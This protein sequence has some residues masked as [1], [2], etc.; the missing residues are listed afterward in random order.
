MVVM[1]QMIHVFSPYLDVCP[2]QLYSLSGAAPSTDSPLLK[3]ASY[4]TYWQ[5]MS[6]APPSYPCTKLPKDINQ[7]ALGL[8]NRSNSAQSSS[9]GHGIEPSARSFFTQLF[10]LT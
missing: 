4:N 3:A 1:T 5:L 2:P 6:I 10:I 7:P 8:V 9:S